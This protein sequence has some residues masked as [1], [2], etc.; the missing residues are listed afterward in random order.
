M[1]QGLSETCSQLKTLD[2]NGSFRFTDVSV[3]YIKK[4]TH[5]KI[6]NLKMTKIKREAQKN[7]LSHLCNNNPCPLELYGCTYIDSS[8]LDTLV[9]LIPNIRELRTA[10]IKTNKPIRHCR[11]FHNLK[12]L[13]I[14]YCGEYR[15]LQQLSKFFPHLEEIE[16]TG[17][18]MRPTAMLKRWPKLKKLSLR[19]HDIDINCRFHETYSSLEHLTLITADNGLKVAK[20]L[21]CCRHLK[22]LELVTD[23]NLYVYRELVLTQMANLEEVSLG[24]IEGCVPPATVA[25]LSERCKTTVLL[26]DAQLASV[27]E[28]CPGVRVDTD[29][30]HDITR[31][32]LSDVLAHSNCG[33]CHCRLFSHRK[34]VSHE[35]QH[36]SPAQTRMNISREGGTGRSNC[37]V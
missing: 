31:P 10:Y 35:E 32:A 21:S 4:F 27:Y 9:Q 3:K 29:R 23:S 20:L 6:L 16:F 26:E 37:G 22:T 2:I 30:W 15:F 18:S 7:I 34:L 36:K 33:T 17:T 8:H 24:V 19:T 1:L 12:T 14:D 11:K 13:S 25:L 28:Q 5:I